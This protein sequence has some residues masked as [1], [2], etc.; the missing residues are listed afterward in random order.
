[1]NIIEDGAVM[2]FNTQNIHTTSELKYDSCDPKGAQTSVF[3]SKNQSRVNSQK[4][5]V[6]SN[7]YWFLKIH[8]RMHNSSLYFSVLWSL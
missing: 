6:A 1:M 5:Q 7:K 3:L 2:S 4:F 8:F